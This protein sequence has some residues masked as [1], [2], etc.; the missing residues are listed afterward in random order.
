MLLFIFLTGFGY[1]G[2]NYVI[3]EIQNVLV[4][5]INVDHDLLVIEFVEREEG[6][7][8]LKNRIEIHDEKHKLT[9]TYNARVEDFVNLNE[10]R[11]IVYTD[12]EQVNIVTYSSVILTTTFQAI[13]VDIELNLDYE[14]SPGEQLSFTLTFTI[15]NTFPSEVNS[16]EDEVVVSPPEPIVYNM[17]YPDQVGQNMTFQDGEIK[18][19]VVD[20][21]SDSVNIGTSLASYIEISFNKGELEIVLR[22]NLGSHNTRFVLELNGERHFEKTLTDNITRTISLNFENDNNVVRLRFE[23]NTLSNRLHF[24]NIIFQ[25]SV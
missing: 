1:F 24:E 8:T 19:N 11:L 12:S 4:G 21:W 5:N 23:H 14:F 13:D 15:E 7:L 20:V 18:F 3:E 9:Y 6:T 22:P 25:P 17:T 16:N 10:P 2:V